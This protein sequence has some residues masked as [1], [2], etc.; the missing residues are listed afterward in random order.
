MSLKEQITYDL[1]EALRA[2]DQTRLSTL[3]L[4]RAA[5]KNAEIEARQPLTEDE[6]AAIVNREIKR[7]EESIAAYQEAERADLVAKERAELD[8]LRTY[9]PAQLSE[10]EILALARQVI[11]EVGAVSPKDLGKVMKTIMPQVRG[12]ADGRVVNTLVRELLSGQRE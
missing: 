7:R 1:K 12:R 3:R 4:L 8:V 5:I 2:Q 11:A 9:Q 6:I 10:E